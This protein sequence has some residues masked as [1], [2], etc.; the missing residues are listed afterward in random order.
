MILKAEG[1]QLDILN[2]VQLYVNGITRQGRKK[3]VGH[4]QLLLRSLFRISQ[5]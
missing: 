3:G 1:R 2:F 4:F 5:K